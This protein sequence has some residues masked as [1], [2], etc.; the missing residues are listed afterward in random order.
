MEGW[1][2]PSPGTSFSGEL[3]Q[4]APCEGQLWPLVDGPHMVQGV[5]ING[6]AIQWHEHRE[7]DV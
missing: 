5:G 3:A 4:Q 7:H 2:E 1:Q 6:T